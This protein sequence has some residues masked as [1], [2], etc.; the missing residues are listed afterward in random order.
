[1]I[2]C[3]FGLCVDLLA[4]PEGP[5][6]ERS[7][8]PMPSLDDPYIYATHEASKWTFRS[9]QQ[10]LPKGVQSISSA[11]IIC[12][13]QRFRLGLFSMQ[14]WME[15][16]KAFVNLASS[17][18]PQAYTATAS[19]KHARPPSVFERGRYHRSYPHCIRTTLFCHAWSLVG[20]Y[21]SRR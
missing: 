13:I 7:S 5:E 6:P 2:C 8:I 17:G 9:H 21:M 3:F 15:R 19:T 16:C 1:M 10:V 20:S 4:S 11:H 12:T 14:E 18:V